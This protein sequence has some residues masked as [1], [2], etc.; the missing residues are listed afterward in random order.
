V[1]DRK[2]LDEA[3]SLADFRSLVE[4]QREEIAG[5]KESEQKLIR[6]Q[7]ELLFWIR[8]FLAG[9]PFG[10]IMLEKGQR[11]KAVNKIAA[12]YLHYSDTELANQNISIVFP[13]IAR[14]D[15]TSKPLQLLAKRKEGETFAA[16]VFV[17]SLEMFGE[18][19]LFVTIQDINERHRLERFRHE[20]ISMVSHDLRAPLTSVRV[21]LE[22]VAEG[23]YGPLNQRGVEL[24]TQGVSNIEYL[25]SLVGNLLESENVESGSIQLDYS[26]TT[27]GSIIKTANLALQ[28]PDDKSVSIETEF[29]NDAITVDQNRIVQVLINL[30]SNAIK[31]SPE[32]SVVRIV[33]GIAGVHAR[34]EVID[35][36]PGIPDEQKLQIFERFRQ[37]DQSGELKRKGFGLGL[38]IC[39]SLVEKHQGLIWVESAEGKG[40]KFCFSVPISP[41]A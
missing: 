21:T 7:E 35:Q 29:T 24:V 27:I 18:D 14:L 31:Y 4:D 23:T 34:F 6:R 17:N 22:M 1:N 37:L 41:E 10:F 12:E 13:E 36:G 3:Q 9:F 26:D 32:N 16:E 2:E 19:L 11:I 40:S 8:N 33:A 20:L 38:A 28:R 5:L 39:K 15:V 30:I 25:N